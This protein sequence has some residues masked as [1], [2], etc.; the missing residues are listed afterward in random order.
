MLGGNSGSKYEG[1]RSTWATSVALTEWSAY[2]KVLLAEGSYIEGKTDAVQEVNV[3]E[4]L[5]LHI[6]LRCARR[7]S[8]LK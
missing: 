2:Y 7:S 3:V 1:K 4:V 5:G 8:T 6:F